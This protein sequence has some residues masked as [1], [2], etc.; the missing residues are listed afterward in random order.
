MGFDLIE[1]VAELLFMCLLL[2]GQEQK[3]LADLP[4]TDQL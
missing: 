2:F 3:Q 4:V 1:H